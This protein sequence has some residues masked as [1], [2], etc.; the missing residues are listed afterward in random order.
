[1]MTSHSS[2][3]RLDLAIR[4]SVVPFARD[5]VDVRGLDPIEAVE[6]EV[7]E[8]KEFHPDELAHLG[9]VAGVEASGLEA[10]VQA[11]GSFE[12]QADPPAAGDVAQ[13][14]GGECFADADPGMS[15]GKSCVIG[16]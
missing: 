6:G 3:A 4:G 2:G 1:M 14:G 7:I 15:V 13:R 10:H 16:V 12:V 11:V 9:F 8:D 5:V